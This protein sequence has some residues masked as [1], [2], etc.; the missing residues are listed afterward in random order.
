M[1][2]SGGF[3]VFPR[4][5]EDVLTG[6]PDVAQGAVFGVPHPNW[7]EAVHAVV[8]RKAGATVTEQELIDL[9]KAQ[10]GS[11]PAPK[12]V[13]FADALPAIPAGKVDKKSLRAPH[14]AGRDRQVG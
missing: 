14:W 4:Q 6:H 5:V 7:G 2:V 12:T 10:L 3:N 11:V 8:V 9:V 13:E 1:V